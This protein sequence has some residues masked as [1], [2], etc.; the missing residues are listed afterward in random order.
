MPTMQYVRREQSAR[1][2]SES[3][4]FI[5]QVSSQ[6]LNANPQYRVSEVA[7]SAGGRTKWHTHT[8]H[9]VL[10]ITEGRGVVATEDEER[11]VTPGDVL[12]IEPGTRHW[13]G[14]EPDAAMTHLSLN[15][16]G[17]TSW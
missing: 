6:M 10:V 3:D 12:Y 14:A 1:A 15:G 13:H 9:Q 11:H 2:R 16:E 7:F 4:I 5:G 8:F 17:E